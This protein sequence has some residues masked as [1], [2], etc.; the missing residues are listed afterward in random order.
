ME[1][2]VNFQGTSG[3]NLEVETR[4]AVK[5]FKSK[6][7]LMLPPRSFSPITER[8]IGTVDAQKALRD[9]HL[10]AYVGVGLVRSQKQSTLEPH[11]LLRLTAPLI[12]PHGTIET[13]C[14]ICRGGERVFVSSCT[15]PNRSANNPAAS[16]RS[17]MFPASRMSVP[18]RS[19]VGTG[20]DRTSCVGFSRKS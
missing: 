10:E 8:I 16:L 18:S 17:F 1:H 12:L 2:I 5:Y 9:D 3:S 4:P 6:S 20:L 7:R 14:C 19:G 13:P 15:V 11:C